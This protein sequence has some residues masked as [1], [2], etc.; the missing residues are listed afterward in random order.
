[1]C[2]VAPILSQQINS[3]IITPRSPHTPSNGR[4]LINSQCHSD[5]FGNFLDDVAF[6]EAATQ[7]RQ[8]ARLSLRWSELAPPYHSPAS[9][10]C[11]PFGSK[12][13]GGDTLACGDR[14]RWSQFGRGDIPIHSDSLGTV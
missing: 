13:G 8:S 9:E 4:Q 7:I 6:S 12:V 11:P 1:M 3:F 14:G 5:N 2:K 10:C